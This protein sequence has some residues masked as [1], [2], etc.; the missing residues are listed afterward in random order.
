[1]NFRPK[2]ILVGVDFSECGTAALRMA[3]AIAQKFKS[4]IVAVHAEA[5]EGLPSP[6]SLTAEESIE[7]GGEVLRQVGN[8][9]GEYFDADSLPF[10]RILHV[11]PAE[12]ILWTARLERCDLIVVGTHGRGGLSRLTLGSVA[13]QVLRQADVPVLTVRSGINDRP[14]RRILC[15]V[16]YSW[17]AGRALDH[18]IALASRFSAELIVLYLIESDDGTANVR[19]EAERLRVWAGEEVGQLGGA[20]MVIRRGNPTERVIRYASCNRVD[21]IVIGAQHR[22]FSDVTVIGTTTERITRQAPCPVLTVTEV[23]P[24]ATSARLEAHQQLATV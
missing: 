15:P 18:A 23:E 13:E 6:G 14:I 11:P 4:T 3:K 1:M 10:V 19:A 2:R 24:G 22:R 7:R 21:L 9:L 12:A 5:P 17:V 20:K 8:Y 16:N